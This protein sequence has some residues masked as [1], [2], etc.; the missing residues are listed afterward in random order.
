MTSKRARVLVAL[1]LAGSTPI[2]AQVPVFRDAAAGAG[3]GSINATRLCLSDLNGDTRPD[4]VIREV[5]AGEPDRYRV[6]LNQPAE[7]DPTFRFVEKEGHGL[8]TPR[9]GDSLVFSD[10]DNDGRRDA[11]F[12]R[13]LDINSD[14]YEPPPPPERTSW[15][16]GR[17]DGTFGEPVLIEG[18]APATSACVAVGDLDGDGVLD[19]VIGNWYTNYGASN[20]AFPSTVLRG[21]LRGRELSYEKWDLGF[22]GPG[23]DE[24]T[25][26]GGRPTYGVMIASVTGGPRPDILQLNYGRRWNR[27][28]A[29]DL[30]DA[31]GGSYK[32]IAPATGFDGDEIRHGKYPEWLKE[33]AK[34]DPRFDRQDEKPFR[35]NGN[36]F[37]AAVGDIDRDGDFD[38][39][40]SEITHGWAGESSD[41][42]RF[43]VNGTERV[44]QEGV[45]GRFD[46][47]ASLS[48]DRIPAGVNNWN[49]GDLFCELADFD[50]DGRLDLLLSSGDY[51]DNQRL[52]LFGQQA[53]GTFKDETAAAGLDH[54]GSQQISLGDV[55][56]DG[57]L[58]ILVGQSFN[59]LSAEQIAGRTPTLKLY[60][61]QT[62]EGRG[63]AGS[64]SVTLLLRGG[65]R[66]VACVDALNAIVEARVDDDADPATPPVTIVRQLVGPGGHAGKQHEFLVHIGLGRAPGA[67]D[68]KLRCGR[69]E[70]RVGD[71]AAGRHL[72][73]ITEP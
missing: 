63:G 7:I 52:R 35:A 16:P 40:I 56:L 55:D 58:D 66:S 1:S 24:E 32:D 57:D 25:D 30:L 45:V 48:V 5:R 61:N 38:V 11:L 8:P 67:T 15:L 53:D 49:Q 51:P 20:E 12:V 54:E 28:L 26:S 70:M 64:G 47:P 34:T 33:R 69:F 36:T 44:L 21:R 3:I 73:R 68:V 9:A 72:V 65:Q 18:A 62:V 10:L 19:I 23:F 27:L 71:L 31:L 46:S 13:Y 50:H 29:T 43:L 60:L 14:K 59:R 17:G 6:F 22:E 39:F 4:A 37:D 42:S 2:V 41:R